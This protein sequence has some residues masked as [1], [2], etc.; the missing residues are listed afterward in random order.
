MTL[1]RLHKNVA[2][3][4]TVAA[5][6]PAARNKLLAPEGHA[7]VAAVAGL[8][9]DFGFIN[10]HVQSVVRYVALCAAPMLIDAHPMM[11]AFQFN[12]R[13]PFRSSRTD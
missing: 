13:G 2:A 1:G 4:T 3:T 6:G 9:V 7:T 10:K 5:G 12:E 11:P 8:Y